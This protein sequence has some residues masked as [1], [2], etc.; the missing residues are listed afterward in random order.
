MKM[1]ILINEFVND[2]AVRPFFVIILNKQTQLKKVYFMQ[3]K[4]KRQHV[5]RTILEKQLQ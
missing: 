1:K 2:A 3:L 4:A 5:I